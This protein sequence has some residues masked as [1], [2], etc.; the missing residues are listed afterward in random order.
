MYGTQNPREKQG[1]AEI[2]VEDLEGNVFYLMESKESRKKITL[3]KTNPAKQTPQTRRVFEEVRH[4]NCRETGHIKYT[5][6][7]LVKKTK[8]D[9]WCN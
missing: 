2:M 4:L 6:P 9:M 5:S 8:E 1:V 3:Q 7:K